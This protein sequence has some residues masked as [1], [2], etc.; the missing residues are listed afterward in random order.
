MSQ[1]VEVLKRDNPLVRDF[2]MACEQW[3]E[4]GVQDGRLIISAKERPVGEHERRYNLQVGF[5]YHLSARVV[6]T[7]PQVC[8]NEVSMLT[9]EG[10]HHQLVLKQRGSGLIE[11]TDLNPASTPLHFTLA[12]PHGSPGWHPSLRQVR[13]DG[14]EDERRVTPMKFFAFHLNVRD[15]QRDYLFQMGRLFQELI[16]SYRIAMDNSRLMWQLTHQVTSLPPTS[17]R[18]R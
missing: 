14:E 5:L 11:V 10:A 7:F 12:F 1:I 9:T 4:E 17:L 18:R 2:V 13:P 8:P 6:P 16:I 3:S 15:K